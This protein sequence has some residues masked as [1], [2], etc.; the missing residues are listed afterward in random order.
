[1][2]AN[3]S[4]L[5]GFL[6]AADLLVAA[7]LVAT[8]FQTYWRNTRGS[9]SRVMGV[10][11]VAGGLFFAAQLAQFFALLPDGTFDEL[12]AL[13]SLVFLLL[14]VLVVREIGNGMLAHEHLVK[15]KQKP[16]LA[17]VE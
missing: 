6:E 11:V 14:L 5:M 10:M 3:P 4:F 13:F 15:R 17:D 12:Q 9:F 8:A 2:A 1:M 16:R 7:Y